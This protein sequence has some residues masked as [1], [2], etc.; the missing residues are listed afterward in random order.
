M[1]DEVMSSTIEKRK[2]DDILLFAM[3]NFGKEV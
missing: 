2:F 1:A 3:N